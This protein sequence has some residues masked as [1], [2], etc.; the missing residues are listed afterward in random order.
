MKIKNIA[1]LFL[2]SS[3]L[4]LSA[5]QKDTDV[6]IPDPGQITGPDTN[7]VANI[8]AGMPVNILKNNLLL[9]TFTDSIEV[10][11]NLVTINSASGLT[12]VF[13]P[14]CCQRP[15]GT[16]VTGKVYLELL[17]VKKKGDMIRMAKPTSS[18]DRLLVSGGEFFI[19]MK[20]D[21][22]ELQLKPGTFIQ[23]KFADPAPSP[24][25]KVFYGDESNANQFNWVPADS[26]GTASQIT[27]GNGFY[28]LY[29]RNL[30]WVNCDYFYDTTGATR[31]KVQ[32]ELPAN[33]T[34]ANTSVYMVFNEMKTVIGMYGDLAT[35]KFISGKVPVGKPITVIVLSKQGDDYY[36]GK[37]IT[38]SGLNTVGNNNQHV[39]IT[40]IKTPLADIK[41]YLGTL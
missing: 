20:K 31:V 10:N 4:F 26:N 1:T 14:L 39:T 8:N 22:E 24:L 29:S 36:L 37:Q 32:T 16:P 27:A 21:G 15:N 30:R 35:R 12:C 5:C 40:P 34:N 6:F 38:T 7:W 23:V 3:I 41:A 2:I 17:L 25:M 18:N 33:F 19:K 11:A 28:Q 13:P 9:E